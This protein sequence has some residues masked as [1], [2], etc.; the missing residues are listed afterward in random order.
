MTS[1]EWKY[2]L[3]SSCVYKLNLILGRPTCLV[4]KTLTDGLELMPK[5]NLNQTESTSTIVLYAYLRFSFK[6]EASLN[7]TSP[8]KRSHGETSSRHNECSLQS[9]LSLI[10][11]DPEHFRGSIRSSPAEFYRTIHRFIKPIS[12]VQKY[13]EFARTQFFLP[14]FPSSSKQGNSALLRQLCISNH[15]AEF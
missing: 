6:S 7:P 13:S 14:Q 1:D 11:Q 12:V 10:S 5:A 3:M 9:T 2:F 4:F 8:Y 15:V